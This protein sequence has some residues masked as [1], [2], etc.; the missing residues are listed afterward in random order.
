MWFPH[1]LQGNTPLQPPQPSHTRE[2]RAPLGLRDASQ[3]AAWTVP[4][5]NTAVPLCP[6]GQQ[7]EGLASA[8]SGGAAQALPGS[9]PSPTQRKGQL[10]QLKTSCLTFRGLS[11]P[12]C[13]M[14]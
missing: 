13:K 10:W 6:R 9:G 12:I 3:W 11:L 1:L 2:K 7:A 8:G 5:G 14:G 4:A